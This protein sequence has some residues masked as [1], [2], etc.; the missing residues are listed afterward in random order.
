M[1]DRSQ[2][3]FETSFEGHKPFSAEE[4]HALAQHE[5]ELWDIWN[6]ASNFTNEKPSTE[7]QS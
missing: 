5:Q 1:K 4:G 3:T 7:A 6:D 2:I